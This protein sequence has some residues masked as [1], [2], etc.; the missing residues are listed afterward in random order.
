MRTSV[1]FPELPTGWSYK[2]IGSLFDENTLID[3][4]DGNHGSDYPRKEEFSKE[5]AVFVTA[6]Q[7]RDGRVFF[8]ECPRLNWSKAR[9]LR[10]GWARTGDVLLTHN[11]TVGRVA[12]VEDV[13]E[14]FLL[15]TSVTYYRTNQSLLLNRFLYWMFCAPVF[16]DQL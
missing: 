2:A 9:K 16:Q 14:P 1:D 15:G 10:K 4:A 12:I 6:A 7:I 11:A 3:F 13:I 8:D 5:G